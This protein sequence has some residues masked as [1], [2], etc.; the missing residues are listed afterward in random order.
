[1]LV[2][3]APDLLYLRTRIMTDGRTSERSF[4]RDSAKAIRSTA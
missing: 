3:A 1:M 2:T 4:L